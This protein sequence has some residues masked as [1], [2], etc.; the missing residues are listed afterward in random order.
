[1]GEGSCDIKVTIETYYIE[2]EVSLLKRMNVL[3][4][5]KV[6]NY[7]HFQLT[8]GI[9]GAIKN[10]GIPQTI[11]HT[12][13]VTVSSEL[14]IDFMFVFFVFLFFVFLFVI[15]FNHFRRLQMH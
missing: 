10:L 4:E 15:F 14:V 13:F 3:F 12:T 11:Q 8:H 1:M 9:Y 2:N 5:I 6:L 7:K